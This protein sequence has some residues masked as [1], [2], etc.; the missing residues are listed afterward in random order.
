MHRW[1]LGAGGLMHR[2][3]LGGSGGIDAQV[4]VGSGRRDC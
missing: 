2:W 1:G 4:G 3:G